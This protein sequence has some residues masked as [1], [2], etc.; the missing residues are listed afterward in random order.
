MNPG[1]LVMTPRY[2]VGRVLS[3]GK[4]SAVVQ[5]ESATKILVLSCLEPLWETSDRAPLPPKPKRPLD[6]GPDWV[7]CGRKNCDLA[8]RN[9][10]DQ[11]EQH[12][13]WRTPSTTN[14]PIK[15]SYCRWCMRE[16]HNGRV[17]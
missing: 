5:C 3:V 7:E 15:Q 1:Q 10:A 16:Y 11:I 4:V 17:R 9:D 6:V 12:F 14:V 13:G 2:G 8:C